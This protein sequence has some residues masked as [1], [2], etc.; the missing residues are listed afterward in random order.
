MRSPTI[1]LK[2]VDFPT[3]GLPTTAIT[4]V[5]ILFL[6]FSN[7]IIKIVWNQSRLFPLNFYL[8]VI[9]QLLIQKVDHLNDQL[10]RM[11]HLLQV[12]RKFLQPL[13]QLLL[14]QV[15]ELLVKL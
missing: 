3:F 14:F 8:N 1:R 11:K 9:L 15:L 4:G 10:K 12:I 7:S 6:L 13:L 5:D 2:I